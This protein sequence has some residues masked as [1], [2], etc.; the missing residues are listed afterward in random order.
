[1][2][3]AGIVG[4]AETESCA[5]ACTTICG[6]PAADTGIAVPSF[7]SAPVPPETVGE[8]TRCATL[9]DVDVHLALVEAEEMAHAGIADVEVSDR[10]GG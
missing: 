5:G 9:H 3:F 2:T 10:L 4:L 7:A 8:S 1:M 6:H